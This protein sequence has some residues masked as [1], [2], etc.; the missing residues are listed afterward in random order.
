VNSNP[1]LAIHTFTNNESMLYYKLNG[2]WNMIENQ[3]AIDILE[4]I[5]QDIKSDNTGNKA[6]KTIDI[7]R[8]NLEVATS[9]RIRE[10]IEQQKSCVKQ[11][12]ESDKYTIKLN[13]QIDKEIQKIFKK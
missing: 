5:K 1:F 11:Y 8:K 12:G 9:P 4:D 6:L 2:G 13:K 7:Y 3:V 10:L